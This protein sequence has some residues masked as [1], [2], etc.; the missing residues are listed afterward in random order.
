MAGSLLLATLAYANGGGYVR[1]LY[2]GVWL[3]L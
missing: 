2:G 3:L 1:E